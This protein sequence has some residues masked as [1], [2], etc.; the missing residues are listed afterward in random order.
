M[1]ME[2]KSAPLEWDGTRYRGGPAMRCSVGDTLMT[3]A[4]DERKWKSL[5]ALLQGGGAD[6]PY[7]AQARAIM[8]LVNLLLL[9][10][11]IAVRR[12]LLLL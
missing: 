5:N 1:K 11:A 10:L 9:W 4:W 8:L 12:P 7:L 6:A 2:A 3:L